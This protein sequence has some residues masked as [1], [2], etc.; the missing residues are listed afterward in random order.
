MGIF[1]KSLPQI[2]NMRVTRLQEKVLDYAFTVKWVAGKENV[3]ADTLTCAPAPSSAGAMA[4][5]VNAC[6]IAPQRTLCHIIESAK[7]C[8]AYTKIAEQFKQGRELA[9][10]P[11]NH[12]Y[13][14]LKNVWVT[15]L[16]TDNGI[17]MIDG[18][19]IYIPSGASKEIL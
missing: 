15:V 4:L 2:D 13:R 10:L 12:P 8:L 9:N 14:K 18:S 16:M 3:I 17:I 6:V 1:A 19:R 7:A 11:C 5:P